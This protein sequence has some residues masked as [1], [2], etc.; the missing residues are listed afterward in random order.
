MW[1]F[2]RRPFGGDRKPSVDDIG[3]EHMAASGRQDGVGGSCQR[4]SSKERVAH[5][6]EAEAKGGKDSDR[7]EG[8]QEGGKNA[9]TR[10]AH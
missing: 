6:K 9:E 5:R 1:R 2:V 7:Q 8:K 4:Q 3:E 10:I